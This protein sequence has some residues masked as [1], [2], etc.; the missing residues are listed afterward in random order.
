MGGSDKLAERLLRA[1]SEGS[2]ALSGERCSVEDWEEDLPL[3][4]DNICVKFKLD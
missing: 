1:G 3:R 4:R 2:A